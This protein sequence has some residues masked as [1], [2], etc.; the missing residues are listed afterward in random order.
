MRQ[1]L[2]QDFEYKKTASDKIKQRIDLI[3][4]GSNLADLIESEISAIAA[5]SNTVSQSQIDDVVNKIYKAR[6][7]F[8]V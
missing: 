4:K 6:S 3:E 8:L 5:I 2:R 7:I 1:K